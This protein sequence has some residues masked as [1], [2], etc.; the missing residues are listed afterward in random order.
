MRLPKSWVLVWLICIAYIDVDFAYNF[1][2]CTASALSHRIGKIR[3][4]AKAGAGEGEGQVDNE[5]PKKATKT[6]KSGA[7]PKKNGKGGKKATA[8]RTPSPDA[9][10]EGYP[11]PPDT[12]RA[13]RAGSKRNYAELTGETGSDDGAGVGDDGLDKKVNI[14][15]GEDIGEGLRQGPDDDMFT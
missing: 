9:D 14:A 15:V 11:T 4:L 12:K 2:E 5:K 8:A 3:A 10:G 6:A 13:K 7:A 1:T